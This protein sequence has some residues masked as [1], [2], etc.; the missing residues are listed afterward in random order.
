MTDLSVDAVQQLSAGALVVVA[1][2][3]PGVGVSTAAKELC[4]ALPAGKKA[5]LVR[6]I[7]AVAPRKKR[8]RPEPVTILDAG[9]VGE[10]AEEDRPDRPADLALLVVHEG[11]MPGHAH[12]LAQRLVADFQAETIL[13][14]H[15]RPDQPAADD[16]ITNN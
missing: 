15:R 6:Q 11:C 1:G 12:H 8:G 3:R 9:V 16:N 13:I 10:W 4:S 7:P 2:S 14:R 5:V